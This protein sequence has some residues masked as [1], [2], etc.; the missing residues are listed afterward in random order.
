MDEPKHE[1]IKAVLWPHG[2]VEFE[3]KTLNKYVFIA[4][5]LTDAPVP[6]APEQLL[7]GSGPPVLT[8][9]LGKLVS[10]VP[11]F[12]MGNAN[13]ALLSL[14]RMNPEELDRVDAPAPGAAYSHGNTEEDI[15]RFKQLDISDIECWFRSVTRPMTSAESDHYDL[16]AEQQI[17]GAHRESDNWGYGMTSA[18]DGQ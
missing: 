11:P 17:Q 6:G 12:K 10:Y 18:E 3:G 7:M 16:L 15:E 14:G 13:S 9:L 4:V 8:E 5:V 1:A 2:Q